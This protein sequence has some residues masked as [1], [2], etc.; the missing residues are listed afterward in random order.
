MD[1]AAT[2]IS[3]DTLSIGGNPISDVFQ[4]VIASPGVTDFNGTVS[5]DQITSSGTA[6]VGTLVAST[7]NAGSLSSTSITN[8]G[9]IST[10]SLGATTIVASGGV[11][12]ATLT[13]TVATPTQNSITKIGTQTSFASSGNISQTGGTTTLQA[14]TATSLTTPTLN[15]NNTA[16]TTTQIGSFL[17][18][19]MAATGSANLLVG[20]SATNNNSTV[21]GFNYVA[22]GST[23]NGLS[24]SNYGGTNKLEVT[25]TGTTVTGP[26]TV[27]GTLDSLASHKIS[28]SITTGAATFSTSTFTSGYGSY[29]IR[30]FNLGCSGNFT[31]Y[32]QFAKGTTTYTSGYRVTSDLVGYTSST[33]TSTN[34]VTLESNATGLANGEQVTGQI[35]I[36]KIS[37]TQW[38]VT[39]F[40]Q[41]NSRN[42]TTIN[43]IF[44]DPGTG[45]DKV[46]FGVTGGTL[47]VA[48]GEYTI[49]PRP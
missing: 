34:R 12:G 2:N 33:S 6:T 45:I 48:A 23:S 35:E 8:T 7:T 32:L 42:V 46:V 49:T 3:T 29:V 36:T 19:S 25:G 38:F 39:G 10:L 43:G 20:R 4:N 26:L 31:P 27:V 17:T 21:V 28:G 14:T 16:T 40:S 11:S 13:G 47:N 15:V 1:L 41:S 37:A 9:S 44:G 24:I 5:A 22:S 18:P 30:W